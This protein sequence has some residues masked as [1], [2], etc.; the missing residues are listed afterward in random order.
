MV[1]YESMYGNT[2]AIAEAIGRGLATGYE[3]TVQ[4]VAD[5]EAT[6]LTGVD[7]LVVGGPTHTWSMSRPSTRQGAAT[8][9]EKPGS[10]LSIEP[11]ATGPG[12]REWLRS[13]DRATVPSALHVTTFDTRMHAP[14]GLS[15]A[16]SRTIAKRLRRVGIRCDARPRG[17]YVS[18]QNLL[19][20][21]EI[22][23]AEVWG[24]ELAAMHARTA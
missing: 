4:P 24:R 8:A 10:G 23:R 17:F 21:G 7:L 13:L 5:V 20:D 1:I 3:V 18:R 2:R 11:G 19:I 15:G 16:A 6:E 9:A 14:L 12:I 22:A